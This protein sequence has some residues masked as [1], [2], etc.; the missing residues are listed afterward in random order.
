MALAEPVPADSVPA[1]PALADP[2]LADPVSPDPVLAEPVAADPLLA[3]PAPVAA[4]VLSVGLEPVS[5]E[6]GG[7]D[8][9]DTGVEELLLTGVVAVAVT[10]GLAVLDGWA[11]LGWQGVPVAWPVCLPPDALE[12]AFAEAGVLALPVAVEAALA[13]AVAV[14]VPVAVAVALFPGLL[15]VLSVGGLLAEPRTRSAASPI[16]PTWLTWPWWTTA[17]PADTRSP[18]RCSGRPRYRPG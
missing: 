12:L 3:D 14:A 10:W 2:A 18:A 7:L 13:V 1:D 6:A 9:G 15:L 16:C 17:K 5:P 4:G 11:E 8:V